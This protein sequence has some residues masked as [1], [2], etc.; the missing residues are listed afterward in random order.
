MR[1]SQATAPA[2]P[3]FSAASA[4]APTPA[5]V[6]VHARRRLN[7]RARSSPEVTANHPKKSAK[8]ERVELDRRGGG[9]EGEGAEE[10]R[11]GDERDGEARAE[12]LEVAGEAEEGWDVA[13]REEGEEHDVWAPR[14]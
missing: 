9:R 1:S 7:L 2:P 4:T 14:L 6:A 8:G 12:R 10:A 5:P 13:V 3:P 11:G